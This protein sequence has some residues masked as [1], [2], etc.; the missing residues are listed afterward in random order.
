MRSRGTFYALFG[1]LFNPLFCG[2]YHPITT[3]VN[4]PGSG[5][6]KDF[7][8][9]QVA[10]SDPKEILAY[11]SNPAG[12]GNLSF[13][14]RRQLVAASATAFVPG[15]HLETF[16]DEKY[17]VRWYDPATGRAYPGVGTPT[18]T[19]I[20]GGKLTS[21][22]K[23]PFAGDAILHITSRCTAPNVCE[24]MDSA[25]P[26]HNMTS[27]LGINFYAEA[28]ATLTLDQT[29]YVI[30]NDQSD[31]GSWRCD[32]NVPNNAE[33]GTPGC[34]LT[35]VF[36]ARKDYATV[37]YYFKR[38]SRHA[39]QGISFIVNGGTSSVPALWGVT[40]K[41]RMPKT[42]NIK[43]LISVKLPVSR[44]NGFVIRSV[45]EWAAYAESGATFCDQDFTPARSEHQCH[46]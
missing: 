19:P 26:A 10:A 2:L 31:H 45:E 4:Q 27:T 23:P 37:D 11:I 9:L 25:A 29:Q 46:R 33:N 7:G 35:H 36:P 5:A 18:P 42:A 21:A 44:H 6:G 17:D 13:D 15:V 8:R 40:A 38:N 16:P 28:P 24:P 12:V 41:F 20:P 1:G 39:Y 43:V 34:T 14:N 3:L 32:R 22:L 30:G